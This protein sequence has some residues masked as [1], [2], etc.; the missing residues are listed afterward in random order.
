MRLR[1]THILGILAPTLVAA[2]AAAG[3][4]G[5]GSNDDTLC[6]AIS[7]A[8]GGPVD[9][10]I[11]EEYWLVS[12]SYFDGVENHPWYCSGSQINYIT[13]FG[14]F[15]DSW[16]DKGG[17]D[18]EVCS[19]H[20][21][22]DRYWNTPDTPLGRMLNGFSHIVYANAAGSSLDRTRSR[23][24]FDYYNTMTRWMS[25]A[26]YQYSFWID[27]LCARV[28]TASGFCTFATTFDRRVL[29]RRDR[30]EFYQTFYYDIDSLQRAATIVHEARHAFPV[31]HDG[32]S[33]SN[34]GSCDEQWTTAGANTFE[35]LWLSA[36]KWA[37]QD[38]IDAYPFH[39]KP[40]DA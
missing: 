13:D 35:M 10:P 34:G 32:N 4:S 3:G 8:N 33:C 21:D 1:M 18:N 20:Q 24:D 26:V 39:Q 17:T 36:Y 38:D 37:N 28:C 25:A 30:I 2:P 19:V 29:N 14:P 16:A 5:G 11:D 23:N 27:G 22:Y 7:E 40:G 9:S 31:T 6:T 12:N 15:S